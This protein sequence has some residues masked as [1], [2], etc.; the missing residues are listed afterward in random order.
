MVCNVEDLEAKVKRIKEERKVKDSRLFEI[1]EEV[2]DLRTLMALYELLNKGII[3]RMYGVIAAGKEARIYWAQTPRGEDVAVKIFLVQSAEF[4]KNRLIYIQ[5]DPRFK[6]VKKGLR[7]IIDLWCTKEFINLNRAYNSG[8]RVPR[9]YARNYNVLVMEFI[10]NP[11]HRGK[12]A[13]LLKEVNLE[14]P[15]ETFNTIKGFIE[16]LYLDAKLVHGD[17]SEYNVMVKGNELILIDFGSAV[18]IRH[19]LATKFLSRDINNI[20]TFFRKLGVK[21]GSPEEFYFKLT[22]MV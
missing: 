12:P 16:R 19:P 21:T 18:D 22:S 20:Y 10:G 9:P 2:F 11:E 14:N 3:S 5:G 7:N 17:F 1:V 15:E 8:V 13:P 4:R 6:K